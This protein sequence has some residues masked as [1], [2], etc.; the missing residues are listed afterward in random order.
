MPRGLRTAVNSETAAVF[1]V[2]LNSSS[3]ELGSLIG[4]NWPQAPT[5]VSARGD[6]IIKNSLD[7]E[8]HEFLLWD[9]LRLSR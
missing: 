1:A 7:L 8:L 4:E 2:P 3:N 9:H 6:P 5:R